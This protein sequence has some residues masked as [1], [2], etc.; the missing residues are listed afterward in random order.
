M[1]SPLFLA[2]FLLAYA[3]HMG[4]AA[5][6]P[7]PRRPVAAAP[8][9]APNFRISN[10]TQQLLLGVADTW[11]NS[12]VTL[13]RFERG[14][15]G[16]VAIGNSWPGRLG[17]SGLVWGLGVHPNPPGARVK[18]ESDNR[19]PAGVFLLFGG[20]DSGVYGYDRDIR[21]SPQ[22]P[23]T[24]VQPNDLWFEDPR[25][26]AYN[27]HVRLP[28]PPRNEMEKK[29]QMK[30][31]DY[32]HALKLFILHNAGPRVVPHA[33]SSI[34]FHIWRQNGGLPTAGCTTMAEANLRALIAWL[35]P[36]AHP[37]FVLLPRAE[38]QQLRAAWQLP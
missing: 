31:N 16:W 10:A 21:R 13:Q 8:Q 20:Q 7:L 22:T 23:Y 37:V 19:S 34:F 35:Q 6:P 29:A 3:L 27:R 33:G 14:P 17:K 18:A 1:K 2:L 26:P 32:A 28:G 11:N 30:Q 25:S 15:Q 5:V 4:C 9:G 12:T 24:Q 36:A 38:Y